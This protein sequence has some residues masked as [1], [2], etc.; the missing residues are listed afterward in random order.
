MQCRFYVYDFVALIS[1]RRLGAPLCDQTRP[2]PSPTI[3][4]SEPIHRA[5]C[6]RWPPTA[7]VG[8]VCGM[9]GDT[10]ETPALLRA[11]LRSLNPSALRSRTVRAHKPWL[12]L[13]AHSSSCFH[14]L[15]GVYRCGV[16]TGAQRSR[17]H[18]FTGAWGSR[19]HE[20]YQYEMR[21]TFS[22]VQ[23]SPDDP[24]ATSRFGFCELERDPH[25]VTGPPAHP[26]AHPSSVTCVTPILKR[27]LTRH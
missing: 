14:R 12:R 23:G 24:R 26:A 15:R 19:V 27:F 13:R 7:V 18:G 11:W 21:C 5:C 20:V 10:F 2:R 6:R 8:M 3:P 4:K 17:V 9:G 16:F 22:Q 25:R 1:A